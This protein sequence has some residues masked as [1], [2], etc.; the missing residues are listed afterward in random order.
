MPSLAGLLAIVVITAG[1]GVLLAFLGVTAVYGVFEEV[2]GRLNPDVSTIDLTLPDLS[3]VSRVYASDGELLAE[4]HDGRVSEPLPIEQ[5]PEVVI[6]AVLAAEDDDFYEHE[7]VDFTAIARTAVYNFLYQTNLGGSTITQQVAK[8]HF[9]GDDVTIERKIREAFVSTDLERTYEK[10]QILE[11]YLNSVY[12]GSGAYGVS[13]AS[14]EFFAKPL[15]KITLEEAATLAVLIRNPAFYNPRV[16]PERTRDRRNLIIDQMVENG[17]AEAEEAERAKNAP[18]EVAEHVPFRGEADHVV[19]EVNRQLL[20]DARFAFLGDTPEQRKKAIFGC[21]ADNPECQG[22]GGLRIETTVDLALQREAYQVL[23]GWLPLPDYQQNVLLCQELFPSDPL[24][25]L[26]SYATEHSCAPTG[27]IVTVDNLTGAVEV[28][29]SGLPF[30][31]IQFDLAIQGRRNPGSSMKPFAL[32]GALERDVSLGTAFPA[33]PNIEIQCPTVCVEDSDIW[34]VRNVGTRNYGVLTLA[35]ATSSSINTVYAQIS[36][37]IG[38]SKVAEVAHRLGIQSDLPPVLSIV[39]GTGAVSPLEMASAYSNFATNGQW[40]SPYIISRI[41]SADSRIL[42]EH[43]VVHQSN[44]DPAAFAAAR[45]PLE[46]VPTPEGTGSRA[47]LGR[48]QGGKTGTHQGFRDA[49]YVG[50]VPTH[51]TAVWVGYEHNQIPLENVV[52]GGEHYRRVYGGSVP[53][54]IWAE[55]MGVMLEDVEATGF[56][57]DP[58]GL[59]RYRLRPGTSVPQVIGL[60][61][62]TAQTTLVNSRLNWEIVDVDS[63][64]PAGEVLSQNPPPRSDALQ[65][66]RIT[67]EVSTGTPPSGLVPDWTGLSVTEVLESARSMEQETGVLVILDLA[68]TPHLLLEA[69]QVVTTNPPAGTEITTGDIITITVS[70]GEIP[71]DILLPDWTGLTLEETLEAIRQLELRTGIV[72]T[73]APVYAPHAQLE[74]ERVITTDPPAGTEI[75]T[76]DIIT[77]TVSN[78]EIPQD[79]LLPDWTGLTL[80]ETLEAIRQLEL[81]TGIVIT[82]AP[83]YAPHAQLEAERVITTDPPAGTEITT[84]DVI[85]ITVSNGQVPN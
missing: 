30:D 36:E 8:N 19:A 41:I 56:P 9:V 34:T 2:T 11:F 72:I 55:F 37:M 17:W 7:G 58:P 24:S 64:A 65:A 39:L 48:P 50:F 67:L 69:D 76:G 71:Q 59:S 40:A 6:Y 31:F 45:I 79:I 52:I 57:P 44:G 23:E 43:E 63:E 85:T 12:F 35:D 60:D 3:R 21:A 49:W 83:V 54:P 46:K 51:T 18:L 80:E 5:I 33:P 38:P 22:G 77:I 20:Y 82:A 42:Y 32:L 62:E 16:R 27:S 73:A 14:R 81:R 84:G 29:A 1:W 78:G 15:E 66:D 74:A 70:N 53:A 10:D 61:L 13:T 28:M 75:T 25:Y 68:Y 4:L 26:E 47:S